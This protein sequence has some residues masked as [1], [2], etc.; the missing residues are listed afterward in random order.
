MNLI[1]KYINYDINNNNHK[2][3]LDNDLENIKFVSLK[4]PWLTSYIIIILKEFKIVILK[5]TITL[6]NRN[7][8]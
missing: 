1:Y 7:N 5:K 2:D 6:S 8:M 3:L 4:N